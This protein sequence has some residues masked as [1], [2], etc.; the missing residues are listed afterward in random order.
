M[1]VVGKTGFGKTKFLQKLGINNF[2]G[3]ILKTEWISGIDINEKREAEIQSCFENEVE[4]H[5]AKEPGELDSL[6]E[7]FKL[8][9]RDLADDDVGVNNS[10]FGKNKKMDRLI[11]MDDVSGVADTSKKFVNFLTV[12]RKFR[13]HCIHLF[14]VIAP[15]TQIWQKIIYQTNIFNIFPSCVPENT[16]AKIIQSNCIRQSKKYV[17]IRSLWLN[18]VFTDLANSDE[19]HCLTIGCSNIIR[20]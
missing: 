1:F 5:I 20:N 7:T 6:L 15:A 16:V 11:V 19:K 17:P 13:Y 18:R 8:R 2:F 9:T 14:H 4:I 10:L 3:K 12:S